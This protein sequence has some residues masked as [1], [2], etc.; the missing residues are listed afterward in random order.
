MDG[1]FRLILEARRMDF[2][3][4]NDESTCS[5]MAWGVALGVDMNAKSINIG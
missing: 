1:R 2:L 4:N 5:R 3:K